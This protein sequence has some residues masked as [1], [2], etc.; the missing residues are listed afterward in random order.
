MT[1][2][3]AI[4]G[5]YSSIEKASRSRISIYTQ[6]RLRTSMQQ[7]LFGEL[8][9]K[10]F[11]FFVQGV[12]VDTKQPQKALFLVCIYIFTILIKNLSFR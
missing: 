7:R 10:S 11:P 5:W 2:L 1:H 12:S 9:K 3:D 6:L 8:F 4:V